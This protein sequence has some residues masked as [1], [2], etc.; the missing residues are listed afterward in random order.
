[1]KKGI[2]LSV[3]IIGMFLFSL[4]L[5]FAFEF[6]N[7]KTYDPISREVTI[8]NSFGLGADIG[9]ARLNTPLNNKVGLGYQKV[10]EFDL[11]A[12]TNYNDILK[13]IDFYNKNEANWEKH[14]IERNFDLKMKSY[15]EVLVY[16]YKTECSN[17]SKSKNK[18]QICNDIKVGSHYETKEIWTKVNQADLKK[19]EFVTIG[20]FTDVQTG[21]Y[22]EWIPKIYG[23]KI[24]E[25]ATWTA[26]LNTGL[27][28]YYTLNETSGTIAYDSLGLNNGTI[29]GATINQTG[30]IG[31]AYDFDG[32]NDFVKLS[33]LDPLHI[34]HHVTISIWINADTISG[35]QRVFSKITGKSSGFAMN[36]MYI[37]SSGNINVREYTTADSDAVTTS[38]T[39]DL[40]T[41]S[42]TITSGTWNHI[43]YSF[44]GT[45]KNQSLY[46]N[47]VLDT[48]RTTGNSYLMIN[49]EGQTTEPHEFGRLFFGSGADYF[50]GKIDEIGIWNR[51]L[52]QAEITA[53]YNSGDGIT[54]INSF[55][56]SPNITLNSPT[57]DTNYTS[58]QNITFNFTVWD[59]INLSDV[60]LYVNDV[61]NQTNTSGI[62]NSVYLFDLTLG[63]GEYEIYGKATDN[64]SQETSSSKITII[65]DSTAPNFTINNQ[66]TYL[67]TSSLPYNVTLNV[68]TSDTHLDSCWYF[69]S[70][71]STNITYTCNT[72]NN[73]SFT[74][75]GDKFISIWANDTL[76]NENNT[77]VSFFLN[78]VTENASYPN[79]AIESETY[80]LNLT[81]NATEISSFTGTLYYNGTAY[82]ASSSNNGTVG[83]LNTSLFID[84]VNAT[85]TK[86]FYWNYTLNGLNYSSVTYNHT[87]YFIN[88]IEVSASCSAG[89]ASAMCFDFKNELNLTSLSGDIN[90]NFKFGITNSSLKESYG[91]LTGISNFCLCVNATVYNNYTLGEGEIQYSKSGYADR[92][93]YVFN[94]TRLNNQTINTTLYMLPNAQSTSFLLEVRTPTLS[95]YVG[96]YTS[97]LKWY[98]ELNE[99]RVVE[100]S[101][102]DDK[103]QTVKKIKIEDVDYRIGVYLTNGSLI[104]MINP[105]RMVCLATPC[106]YTINIPASSV[107]QFQEAYGVE[108]EIVYSGGVFTL[109]YNDPSQNTEMMSLQVYRI[110]GTTNRLI[111]DSNGTSFTGILSCNVSDESGTLKAIAVR[112]ASPERTIAMLIIDTLTTPFTGTFGLFL[113]FLIVVTLAFLGI[114]SPVVAIIMS[115]IALVFG[116]LVFKTMTY[117]MLIGVALLGGIIIHLMRRQ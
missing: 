83:I 107:N 50:D 71:N 60:K 9:K 19:N 75:G 79:P 29:D 109:T 105:V 61:L 97:L 112:T 47:G 6:D 103:G 22:V 21:D 46:I 35:I 110:G 10:A 5:T 16:D 26:N 30:K 78:Y 77:N 38:T 15:E 53:L 44:D 76:G 85:T 98:P 82:T 84:A 4:N 39:F 95:P 31:T 57:E 63:D 93:F 69:T 28:S 99:Y 113:Q 102:T 72:V 37:D 52:T 7:V 108:A 80:S 43:V 18:T 36:D 8:T 13:S 115:L 91:S 23:V 64:E 1:M 106:S 67:V 55:D 100:M 81:I 90:Y 101:K 27:V 92:R 62:N 66:P 42:S 14:Q 58:H 94:T 86:T 24:N 17:D 54:Y 73:I 104:H 114:V 3:F 49:Y 117:P 88:P 51:S 33:T 68:T 116:V 48:S 89:L 59:D 25:W 12:Y 70:D 65:I 20:I 96:V 56:E 34:Y 2:A 41:S 45:T 74:S 32:N 111:C 11:W 87:I 40:I